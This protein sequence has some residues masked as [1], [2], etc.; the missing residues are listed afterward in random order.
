MT[1]DE[2]WLANWKAV[3]DFMETN[4]CRSSKYNDANR[5]YC[6]KNGIK[7]SFVK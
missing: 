1:Q 2:R 7:T 3:M 5:D 4:H 6:K